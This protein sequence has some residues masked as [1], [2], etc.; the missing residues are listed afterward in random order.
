MLPVHQLRNLIDGN[1]GQAVMRARSSLGSLVQNIHSYTFLGLL[2]GRAVF[3]F[4]CEDDHADLWESINQTYGFADL[5]R[6]GPGLPHAQASVLSY[7]RGISHWQ[8]L[9]RFCAACGTIGQL[10]SAGHVLS[11]TSATCGRQWFPRT[12]PAVIMLI[13]RVDTSGRRYCLLG[14]SPQWP[15]QVFSTLAGFVETGESLEQAVVREVYE[16]AGIEVEDVRYIASQ[17][18]PFP[19]S[20]MVGFIGTAV[21]S[22]IKIDPAELA[23]ARWFEASEIA[24]FGNWGDDAPGPKLPRPDSIARYLIDQWIRR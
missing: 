23:D 20:L 10:E 15:E 21:S 11:C 13:E 14:R 12:D 4:V 1:Q 3:S 8:S 17:P 9:N 22:D 2:E 6:V 5:R 19:Q 16:E 18:W 24:T 7:A